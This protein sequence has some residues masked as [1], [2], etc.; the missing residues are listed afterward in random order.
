MP[1]TEATYERVALESRDEELWELWAG[2]L[3]RKPDVTYEHED[4]L[5]RLTGQV[6]RQVDETQFVVRSSN[7]RLRSASGSY[8]IPDLCV[9]AR[10]T[11]ATQMPGSGRLE[12]YDSPALF[13]A[14]VRS[15]ST[16]SYDSAT[17]IPEYRARG[18]FEIWHVEPMLQ[19]VT[20]W[21]RLAGGDYEESQLRA[22]SV[23]LD[24]IPGVTIDIERLWI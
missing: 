9:L 14:E 21:V 5:S 19:L 13:V 23:E 20:R 4:T 17:K 6:Y 10:S 15:P 16:A 12:T 1:I 24:S 2:C 7:G 22:G 18:D 3:R 11:R 8:F